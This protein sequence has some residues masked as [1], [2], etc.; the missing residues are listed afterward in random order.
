V[1]SPRGFGAIWAASFPGGSLPIPRLMD[2][3]DRRWVRGSSFV[4]ACS[5]LTVKSLPS[6]C[7]RSSQWFCLPVSSFQ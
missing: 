5:D 4:D 3:S 2:V 1:M 6:K 7:G